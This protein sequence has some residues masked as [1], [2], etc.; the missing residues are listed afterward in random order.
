MI[1]TMKVDYT[2]CIIIDQDHIGNRD[3]KALTEDVIRGGATLLQYRN[4]S[5]SSNQF[6]HNAMLIHKISRSYHIPLVVNDRTDLALAINA[7][8][9][10]VGQ[11]DLPAGVVRR[12]IGPDK[13]IGISVNNPEQL[14]DTREANYLGVGALF[15]TQTKSDAIYSGLDLIKQV[16]RHSTLPVIGIGGIQM[17][18]CELVIQAGADGIAVISAVLGA[19]NPFSAVRQMRI[20]M[21]HIKQRR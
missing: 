7:E 1:D 10:H 16:R 15:K 3:L 18:N 5:G 17:D 2:L 4:K 6:Y 20:K 14:H 9:V 19:D 21:N 13:L 12:L 11:D 8:G